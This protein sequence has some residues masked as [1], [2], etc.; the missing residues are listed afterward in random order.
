MKLTRSIHYAFLPLAALALASCSSEELEGLETSKESLEG[1]FYQQYEISADCGFNDPETRAV[2]END[3][4]VN[5]EDVDKLIIWT[6]EARDGG[7]YTVSKSNMGEFTRRVKH[8]VNT[9]YGYLRDTEAASEPAEDTP[10]YAYVAS[11]YIEPVYVTSNYKENGGYETTGFLCVDLSEQKGTMEDAMK[12]D[13]LWATLPFSEFKYHEIPHVQFIH[14]MSLLK[15]TLKLEGAGNTTA[16]I[17]LSGFGMANKVNFK[18]KTGL[19][20]SIRVLGK[21]YDMIQGDIML[22]NVEV[23]NDVATVYVALYPSWYQ[24]M[25][26][27]IT[28]ADGRRATASVGGDFD[29]YPYEYT[30]EAGKIYTASAEVTPVGVTAKVGDY[31]NSDGTITSEPQANSVGIVFS[32]ETSARDFAAG[33][34][35]GYVMSL[36]NSSES[37]PFDSKNLGAILT[38][39]AVSPSFQGDCWYYDREGRYETD[40]ILKFR[41]EKGN[42]GCEAA[43]N[44]YTFQPTDTYQKAPGVSD[45]FLPGMAQWYEFLSKFG[46]LTDGLREDDMGYKSTMPYNLALDVTDTNVCLTS[47]WYNCNWQKWDQA[48]NEEENTITYKFEKTINSILIKAQNAGAS[49]S[50]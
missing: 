27:Y 7:N 16:D 19:G 3:K 15:Y 23:K 41:E 2:L 49:V 47:N 33:Y 13:L 21:S 18:I 50:S 14:E 6:S 44:A 10:L 4:A 22:R 26:A 45:W 36:R 38:P 46:G 5:W 32:T 8:G 40:L 37:I 39:G 48:V 28:L 25:Q 1:K 34:V 11:E 30:L 12:H 9:F 35:N 24:E 42:V 20:R 29:K 43:Y 31:Y 17:R